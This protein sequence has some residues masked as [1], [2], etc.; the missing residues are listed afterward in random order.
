[1]KTIYVYL[2][3]GMLIASLAACKEKKVVNDNTIILPEV[4]HQVVD[5]ATVAMSETENTTPVAWGGEY[6]V[7][8]HRFANDSM[9]VVK[10]ANGRKYYENCI[11]VKVTRAD[12]SVFF[13]R[14]FTKNAFASYLDDNYRAKST[15][16]GLVYVGVDANNLFFAGSVGSPDELSDDFVPF[17]VSISRMGDVGITKETVK[18]VTAVSEE[19]TTKKE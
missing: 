1:M 12:G 15:L 19:D 14:N 16:L 13:D 9:G 18:D 8:V 6:K 5:T 11:K 7:Y 10:A 2:S 4:P 17:K 3:A